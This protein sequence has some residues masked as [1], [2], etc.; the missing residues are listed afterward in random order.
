MEGVGAGAPSKF[1][2]CDQS[3]SDGVRF[4]HFPNPPVAFQV[5][6]AYVKKG[7]SMAVP[8]QCGPKAPPS[9]VYIFELKD[10]LAWYE[11]NLCAKLFVDPRKDCV[12]FECERLPYLIKLCNLDGSSLRKPKREIEHIRSGRK[13]RKDYGAPDPERAS[14]LSWMESTITAPS[15]VV[16][17]RHPNIPGDEVYIKEFEKSGARFKEVVVLRFKTVLVPVTSFLVNKPRI[18]GPDDVLWP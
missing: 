15:M 14:T 4:L 12:R 8:P 6:G 17:N 3:V 5:L 18:D 7:L 10:L 16:R 2:P 11:A 9:R 1:I 13:T